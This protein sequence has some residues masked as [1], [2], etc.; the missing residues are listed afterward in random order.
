GIIQVS[1]K[2]IAPGV[3]YIALGVAIIVFGWT[4]VE[5]AMWVF[6][7]MLILSAIGDYSKSK[8]DKVDLVKLLVSVIV[9]GLLIFSGFKVIDWLF[10]VLGVTLILDGILQIITLIKNKK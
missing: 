5:I 10:M 9:G 2:K 1:N 7:V 6:G 8:K 4:L 3:V